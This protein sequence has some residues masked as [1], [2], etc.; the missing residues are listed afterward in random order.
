MQVCPS[1]APEQAVRSVSDWMR[2]HV[3]DPHVRAS[4]R[5][6]YRSRAAYKLIDINS[7]LRVIAPGSTV[8]DLGSAPGSWTQVAVR[9]A[10]AETR[11]TQPDA[12][13]G[14]PPPSI[15]PPPA[16]TTASGGVSRRQRVSVLGLASAEVLSRPYAA[17]A[18]RD[19]GGLSPA[20][21]P[22][23][24]TSGGSGGGLAGCV[25]AVDIS[26]MVDVAGATFIRGDFTKD[27][28]RSAI[29][30]VLMQ[31]GA[32]DGRA[33]AV[34]SDMA[35]SFVGSGTADHA[36]Q[37]RLSWTALVFAAQSLRHGGNVVVKARYG[38]EYRLLCL[39]VKG[40]F[41]KVGRWRR[42]L[43]LGCAL[44]V[45][46]PPIPSQMV[47][48][49]PPASR[50]ESAEAYVVGLG[51]CGSGD[52]AARRAL[53][54]ANSDRDARLIAACLADHGLQWGG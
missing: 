26:P 54:G 45:S 36:L 49:K 3:S 16:S 27:E 29:Q 7:R 15:G 17:T 52:A 31:Q 22:T 9:A 53:E 44:A 42:G 20:A 24:Q 13:L 14:A 21:R 48:V 11:V 5:D 43:W 40:R 32:T 12:I 6:D 25:V 39:A 18:A 37:M 10:R 2:R 33:D 19:R 51:F 41:G 1:S 34:L 28:T 23:T 4:L 46:A 8:I 47:E 38:D 30:Q 50:A 35:H